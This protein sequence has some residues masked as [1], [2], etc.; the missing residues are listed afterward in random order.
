MATKASTL[1]SC[2]CVFECCGLLHNFLLT[3]KD[4]YQ[5]AEEPFDFNPELLSTAAPF[6]A[7]ASYNFGKEWRSAI[8]SRMWSKYISN[9]Q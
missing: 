3:K 4:M 1:N 8:A 7:S 9:T 2:R 6:N 5:D